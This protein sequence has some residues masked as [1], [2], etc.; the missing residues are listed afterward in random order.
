[1]DRAHIK[2]RGSGAGWDDD[3]WIP[4]CRAHHAMQ[5]QIGWKLFT[6]RFPSITVA[7]ALKD[8]HLEQVFGIWKLKKG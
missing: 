4:L 3:E 6:D 2:T 5:G 1:M 8:W 7:L